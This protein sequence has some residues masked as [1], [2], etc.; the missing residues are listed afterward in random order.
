MLGCEYG[1]GYLFS[2]PVNSEGVL[3]LLAQDA[4]RDAEPESARPLTSTTTEDEVVVAY[5]M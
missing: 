2:H 5:S 1:Q 4:H 3:H